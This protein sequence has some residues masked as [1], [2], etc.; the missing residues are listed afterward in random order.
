MH[1]PRPIE[2]KVSAHHLLL[3]LF[4]AA[5]FLSAVTNIL[6]LDIWW[7]LAVGR[8]LV[9]THSFPARDVFSTT[10]TAWDNKEWL[11]GIFVYLLHQEGGA[12]LLALSKAA[13]FTA[14][15]LVLYLVAAKRSG[16]R[17]LSLAVVFLAALACRVRLAFRPE[18][19]SWLFI[20][21]LLLFIEQFR[22]GRRR[23]LCLFPLLMLCWVNVHPL[24]FVGLGILAIHLA[25]GIAVR[26]LPGPAERNGWRRG[27]PGD[28]PVLAL[29]LAAS[30]L[31]FACN[32]LGWRRILS[33]IELLVKHS[34]YLGALTEAAPLPLFQF[35][36]FAAF[37]LLAVFT[38][39]MFVTS[40]EPADTLLILLSGAASVTMA[41][42]APLLPV[43]AAPAIACQLARFI[44]PLARDLAAVFLRRRAAVDAAVAVL[45]VAAMVWAVRRP[46]FG[47]GY[48]GIVYPEGV[49]RYVE[50][51]KP[52]GPLFNIYDWGGFLIW[53]L[54]PGYRVFI[55][56]RGP[57]V[58]PPEVWAEYE[59]IESAGEGWGE[60]LDRR[61]VNLAVVS[62]AEK[63]HPLIRALSASRSWRLGYWDFHS[64]VFLRDVPGNRPLIE[65][66]RYAVLDTEMMRFRGWDPSIEL[67]IL[68][69][70]DD[71]LKEH[72]ESIEARS[73]LGLTYLNRGMEDR[74]IEEFERLAA[75]NPALPRVHYNLGMIHS[76]RGDDA[77]AAAE[78][79]KEIALD[80]SFAPAHNNLGRIRFDRG[81]LRLA[82]RSFRKALKADPDYVHALNN[83]GLVHL[84]KEDTKRALAEFSRALE[85]DPAYEP[86]ARNLALAQEMSSNPAQTLNRMGQFYY[87]RDNLDKAERHFARA[88]SHDPRYAVAIGNLGVVALR[89]REHEEAIRRFREV[90]EIAPDDEGARRHLALAEAMAAGGG[91]FGAP[92][93]ADA[94]PGGQSPAGFAPAP[95]APPG[96][97]R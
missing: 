68:G 57:D 24:A 15:F 50:T 27:R 79:E 18:L 41:R 1:A 73:L 88:L 26:L 25:A 32:P 86:A 16:S 66:V 69:E 31:A 92:P 70:L 74:A 4:L 55:D 38:L 95:P 67:Q 90:L 3:L 62:T 2:W 30:F 61:G 28:L 23:P 84:E 91:Q 8:Y 51:A 81:D 10:G 94:G 42:N 65:A 36:A 20:A 44:G 96:G 6:G 76:R 21:L 5:V 59:T 82:E 37:V 14:V 93:L 46:G 56:G 7:H 80:G 12:G 19:F 63:L 34:A 43:V 45:L 22:E 87:A 97:A 52:L 83:L 49:V 75:G 17:Y 48:N 53:R 78:Y 35:P 77:R 47:L 64:M 13:L 54:Y 29:V 72:P 58:Y 89:R 40:L 71:Y 60:A 11:F 39:V 33:P 85:I 9:Q